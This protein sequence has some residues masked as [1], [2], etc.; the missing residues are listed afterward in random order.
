MNVSVRSNL[1]ATAATV[2]RVHVR[3]EVRVSVHFRGVE[4]G[5]NLGGGAASFNFTEG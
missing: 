3:V 4:N 1:R 5:C 2:V